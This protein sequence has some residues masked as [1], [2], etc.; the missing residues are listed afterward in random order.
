MLKLFAMIGIVA[1]VVIA[2]VLIYSATLPN[3]FRVAR[4][5]TINAPPEKI[6][7]LIN[8][9]R[10]FN[11]WNPFARQDPKLEIAYSGPPNG[12]GAGNG[13]DSIGRAGKGSLEITDNSRLRA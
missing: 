12:K 13:W 8:D 2:A 3:D 4:S 10:S 9:L 7:K 1:A 6:F 5:T 11:Q